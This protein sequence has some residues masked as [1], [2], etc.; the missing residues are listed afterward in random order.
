VAFRDWVIRVVTALCT[1]NNVTPFY[2]NFVSCLHRNDGAGDRGLETILA[3]ETAV[4]DIVD[5]VVLTI[6]RLWNSRSLDVHNSYWT[7]QSGR[8]R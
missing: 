8:R 1:A 4:V 2:A 6:V 7:S 5:G 3:G